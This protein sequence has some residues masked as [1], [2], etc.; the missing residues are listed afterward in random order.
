MVIVVECWYT[1]LISCDYQRRMGSWWSHCDSY[2]KFRT[3]TLL[4]SRAKIEA[5]CVCAAGHLAKKPSASMRRI[6][7]VASL[8]CADVWI[9][10]E[11]ER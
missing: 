9:C 1:E 8:T 3:V 5:A 7:P 4:L 10:R 6:L 2:G 11:R